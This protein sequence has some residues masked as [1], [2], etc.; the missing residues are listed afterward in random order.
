MSE[1]TAND[2]NELVRFQVTDRKA[3]RD[4][5]LSIARCLAGGSPKAERLRTAIAPAWEV[6]SAKGGI[7]AALLSSSLIG[8]EVDLRRGQEAG[9]VADL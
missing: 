9:R 1:L 5:I 6:R 4:L 7:V 3:D 8:A 2:P